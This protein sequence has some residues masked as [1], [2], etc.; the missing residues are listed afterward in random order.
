MQTNFSERFDSALYALPFQIANILRGLPSEVK[1]TVQEIRL[2]CDRPLTLTVNTQVAY[3]DKNSRISFNKNNNLFLVTGTDIT[4]T[5]KNLCN[6]SMYSHTHEIK[7]GFIAM[8]NG[9]RAGVAGNFSGE[10]VYDFSSVNIRIARQIFGAA[11]FLT[12]R[13]SSGGVLIAGPPGSGK[14]TVLRDFI[15]QLSDGKSGKYRRVAVV[16]TRGE[17]SACHGGK[18]QNDLGDNTDVLYGIEKA[19]GVEIALRTLGPD[20]I[21]F[22]EIGTEAELG[23]VAQ[24]M[25]G[26]ADVVLTAHIGKLSELATRSITRKLLTQNNIKLVAML[27]CEKSPEIYS[28]REIE[29][30]LF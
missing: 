7:Q 22:D 14:T 10:T 30:C 1:E 3:V 16:D 11:N 23:A 8:R 4:E 12:E 29:R 25:G 6:N 28:R 26:G 24:C 5:V 13:Y 9:H 15:R 20:I 27:S 21:A 17:I 19:R 2:R 18:M